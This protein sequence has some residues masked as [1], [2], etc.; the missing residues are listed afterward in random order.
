MEV[1]DDQ[2]YTSCEA[3]IATTAIIFAKLIVTAVKS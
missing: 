3:V 1:I 2:E